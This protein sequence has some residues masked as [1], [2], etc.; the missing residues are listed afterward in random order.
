MSQTIEDFV[1]QTEK[2]NSV[3]SLFRAFD[4]F[5]GSFGIDVSSYHIIAK[6]L[7]AVP[8]KDGLIRENFP[9]NW[10]K[11]YIEEHYSDID[12]VIAQARR[13]AKPFHWFE[14]GQKMKLSAVQSEFLS[15][16]K[17]AGLTDGLAV[18][19]FGPEGTMA[20]F[21]LGVVNDILDISDEKEVEIQFA[22]QQVHNRYIE[23]SQ[24]HKLPD[25][26]PVKL[27][28]RE[29]QIL[30]LAATGLSNNYIAERLG[31][32]ENTVDTLMR[33]TFRKLN[34]HN[35]ISAVLRGV[36]SGLILP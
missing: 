8:L 23:L 18:P 11:K 26:K 3:A 32:S 20:Y 27:S 9:D 12:P 25:D 14:V 31:I 29:T 28:P 4:L 7:R 21:G 1:H 35:R 15:E 19:I 5:V 34:V 17:A 2:T 24:E 36:G 22:C 10:V 30:K 33:R 16:L 6:N 13:E